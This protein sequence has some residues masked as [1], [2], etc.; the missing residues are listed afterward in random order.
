ML[1][2]C[3]SCHFAR[4]VNEDKLITE[5]VTVTCPQCK[6]RFTL[7]RASGATTCA[8]PPPGEEFTLRQQTETPPEQAPSQTPPLPPHQT[9]QDRPRVQVTG[10][11]FEEGRTPLNAPPL[12]DGPPPRYTAGGGEE[13]AD[14]AGW[15][16]GQ[17]DF[18]PR[19]MAGQIKN[20]TLLPFEDK[21]YTFWRGYFATVGGLLFKPGKTLWAVTPHG[22]ITRAYW[23]AV[24][25]LWLGFMALNAL[26]C[27]V[28]TTLPSLLPI[29]PDPNL[30]SPV[31]LGPILFIIL[32][33]AF[34]LFAPLMLLVL[35]PGAGLTHLF[36][37]LFGAAGNSYRATFRATVYALTPQFLL[38]LIPL[39]NMPVSIWSLVLAVMAYIRVQRASMARVVFALSAMSLFWLLISIPALLSRAWQM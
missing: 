12:V 32:T 9:S 23:Y 18:S 13:R 15:R 2:T 38:G 28:L 10:R 24:L 27:A 3:P 20:E 17:G 36:L 33:L 25:T 8:P 39:V 4:E 29:P 6:V 5:R 19:A 22:S 1:I 35:F 26:G 14:Q 7:E 37:M 34:A 30:P 21:S 31:F 16:S 11:S